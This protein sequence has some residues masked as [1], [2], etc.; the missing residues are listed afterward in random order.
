MVC[1]VLE[2]GLRQQ[3]KLLKKL[4]DTSV[5]VYH[6]AKSSFHQSVSLDSTNNIFWL[7]WKPKLMLYFTIYNHLT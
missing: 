5:V 2:F 3:L 6:N 7:Q 1:I 4:Y